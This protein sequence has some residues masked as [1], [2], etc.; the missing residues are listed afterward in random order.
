VDTPPG[1]RPLHRDAY[2]RADGTILVTSSAEPAVAGTEK[3]SRVVERVGGTVVG[4]V[5]TKADEAEAVEV[6]EELDI[7]PLAVVPDDDGLDSDPVVA[8]EGGP[9]AEA[10]AQLADA[11]G[12]HADSGSVETVELPDPEKRREQAAVAELFEEVQGEEATADGEASTLTGLKEQLKQGTDLG[13]GAAKTGALALV[14]ERLNREDDFED[15]DID[16]DEDALD[17]LFADDYGTTS[18]DNGAAGSDGGSRLG[19]LSETVSEVSDP[20]AIRDRLGGDDE[21]EDIDT[22]GDGDA[23][24]DLFADSEGE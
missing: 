6:V 3:A 19:S 23:L 1:L 8:G 9:V 13:E 10:Y 18:T 2:E 5:L 14:T 20:E 24:D 4:A 7:P 15:V 17:A 16:D 11:I 12:T 21:L 22:D